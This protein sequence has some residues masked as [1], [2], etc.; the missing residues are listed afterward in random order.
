MSKIL[1]TYPFSLQGECSHE[2]FVEICYKVLKEEVVQ[3]A[4][5]K[6]LNEFILFNLFKFFVH[7][8][9]NSVFKIF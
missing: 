9:K 2:L 1:L 5:D 4:D 6:C 3:S 7:L 8:H